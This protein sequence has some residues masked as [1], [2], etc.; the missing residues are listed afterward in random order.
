MRTLH[1]GFLFDN[2]LFILS[3]MA[4]VG[5]RAINNFSDKNISYLGLAE[6]AF[7]SFFYGIGQIR[8]QPEVN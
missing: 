2:G 1:I 3:L 7:S 4:G 6:K 5:D 8:R